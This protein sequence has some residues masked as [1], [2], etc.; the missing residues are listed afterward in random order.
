M[1]IL[2]ETFLPAVADPNM[3][4]AWFAGKINGTVAVEYKGLIVRVYASRSESGWIDA[5]GFVGKYRTGQKL[6]QCSV[7][8]DTNSTHVMFGNDVRNSNQS[9]TG[10]VFYAPDSYFGTNF[11]SD[12]VTC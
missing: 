7:W 6:W 5:Y 11:V 9:K 4:G 2:P 10:G 1:Q 3:V 12:D 8:F